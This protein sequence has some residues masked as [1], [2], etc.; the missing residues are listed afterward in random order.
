MEMFRILKPGGRLIVTVPFGKFVDYG[1]FINYDYESVNKLF[2]HITPESIREEYF[3]YTS[4]GWAPCSA[5][6]LAETAYGDNSAPAA[7]GLA[8][9]DITKSGMP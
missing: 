2:R 6:D 7:A 8:C 1:W 9:F 3:K 5:D 4:A